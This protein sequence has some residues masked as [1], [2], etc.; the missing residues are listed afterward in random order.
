MV[1]ASGGRGRVG[2]G[3]RLRERRRS[4]ALANG[5]GHGCAS[6]EGEFTLDL[7]AFAL[8]VGVCSWSTASDVLREHDAW[9]RTRVLLFSLQ[10][11]T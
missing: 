5:R 8:D 2:E 1:G 7:G 4:C 11:D 3:A 9:K 10:L 6:K